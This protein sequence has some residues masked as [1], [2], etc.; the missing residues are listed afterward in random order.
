MYIYDDSML[1]CY[2]VTSSQRWRRTS[3]GLTFFVTNTLSSGMWDDQWNLR[4]L[5]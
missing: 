5:T 2:L 4:V 1:H 3:G